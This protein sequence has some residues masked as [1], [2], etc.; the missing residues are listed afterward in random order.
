MSRFLLL[1]CLFISIA[2]AVP[3]E[4]DVRVSVPNREALREVQS[5]GLMIDSY[6]KF[7]GEVRGVLIDRD[8]PALRALGYPVEILPETDARILAAQNRE[9][10]GY[11]TVAQYH[12]FMA[13]VVADHPTLASLDTF[14]FS[15]GGRPLLMMKISNNTAIDQPKPEFCYISTMHGNE[16]PG[17]IFLMWFIDSLTDNYGTDPRVTRMVDSCEIY[18]NPL[19]NPDGYD[20]SPY[21]QR[22]LNSGV[23]MNRNFPVPDGVRGN[24]GTF[25]AYAET[26]A[27]MDWFM[28]RFVSYTIN[29]HGG[30]LLAN[31]PWDHTG[32]RSTDDSL[33]KFLAINYTSRNLPMMN[34][35]D[36]WYLDNGITN[37][38][39]WYEVDGSLQD[40]TIWTRGDLHITVE[41][42]SEKTPEYWTLDTL[43]NHNYDAFCAAVEVLLNH[44]VHGVV[45]DSIT[46]EPLPADVEIIGL[47]QKKYSSPVHGYY[48]RVLLPG[49][50]N[51]KFTRRGYYSKTLSVTVPDSGLGHLDVQL[52]PMS[53]I[54]VYQTDFEADSGGFYT[55]VLPDIQDWRYGT[56][57]QG[58]IPAY[59]GSK[60]WGTIL[61]GEYNNTSQSRLILSDIELPDVDSL[62]LAYR[63]WFSFQDIA[64]GE[65]HDGGNLK[66]WLSSTDSTILSPTPGYDFPMSD[67]N[68]LIA[69]QEAFA[70][71]NQRKWWHEVEVD[72]TPWA[73][74][75][76]DISWDFGSSS[77]NTQ[78]GWYIDDVAIFFPDTTPLH[79]AEELVDKPAE[80]ALNTFPNP[81]NSTVAISISGI[82]TLSR[83][84][85]LE[86][87]TV[88]GR[89]IDEVT[90]DTK[91]SSKAYRWTPD[92]NLGSGIYLI[93]AI[94]EHQT[95]TKRLIYLK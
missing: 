19:L 93:R 34:N 28:G 33:Y 8:L 69:G 23:D 67:W 61:N 30:A 88:N 64:S 32:L 53:P 3:E 49:S 17:M 62:T 27:I 70:G 29:H 86:F 7:S 66:I 35:P 20:N 37:G 58:I 72:L 31:Y 77:V 63:Q 81:F 68:R 10:S 91:T 22:Y 6:D 12:N 55:A 87:Y 59:S 21:P 24:D 18:I 89:L 85:N 48:H 92:K 50:Y 79:H 47:E 52:A 38:Y 14:G 25:T 4:I 73:G 43:W 83:P 26:R 82:E 94:T 56:P 45:T 40:W 39:D 76:V 46:S 84:I 54:Y 78:V 1:L 5:A 95:T 57:G 16:P 41:L 42:S 13:G 71:L 9:P 65:Y 80:I 15:Q 90:I 11:P 75:T 44:G 60:V 51:L 36:P 74:E 2:Y